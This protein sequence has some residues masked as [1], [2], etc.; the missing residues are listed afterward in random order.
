[1]SGGGSGLHIGHALS[2][3]RQR[4]SKQSNIQNKGNN[5]AEADHAVHGQDGAGHANGHIGDIPDNIHQRL[6]NP[7]QKLG[8]PVGGIDGLVQSIKPSCNRPLG[9]AEAHHHVAGIHFLNVAVQL[10]Q[11]LLTGGEIPL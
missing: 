10:A 2:D 1:M 5:H 3:L 6:H 7:G 8:L 11:A 4:R 9:L